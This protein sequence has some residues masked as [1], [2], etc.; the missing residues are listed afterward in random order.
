MPKPNID[1]V[2]VGFA[3]S[4]AIQRRIKTRCHLSY[5]KP[6]DPHQIVPKQVATYFAHVAHRFGAAVPH[7]QGN[8]CGSYHREKV[9]A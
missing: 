4:T 6:G 5:T 2:K 9:T 7:A 1:W 8:L 3:K